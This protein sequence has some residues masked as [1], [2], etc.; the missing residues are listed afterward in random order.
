MKARTMREDAKEHLEIEMKP[1]KGERYVDYIR[2]IRELFV[3]RIP[4]SDKTPETLR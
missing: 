4:K 1:K 3:E 2:R